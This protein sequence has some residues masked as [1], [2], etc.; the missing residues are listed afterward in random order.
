MSEPILQPKINNYTVGR[1]ALY[2][3]PFLDPGTQLPGGERFFGDV[4]GVDFTFK[5]TDLDHYTSLKGIKELDDSV[6][7]QVDRTGQFTTENIE[8]D[9]LA[10]FFLGAQSTITQTSG[11]VTAEVHNA[12]N[13]DRWYQMGATA[14]NPVGTR[15]LDPASAAVV[16][17]DAGSPVTYALGTD[18]LFDYQTGR[19]YTI[20]T[21]TIV[22]GVTN[23]KVTYHKL[24]STRS[25]VIS[26]S[27]PIEGQLHFVADNPNGPSRDA[28]VPWCRITP[29]GNYSLIGDKFQALVF[30]LK[31]LKKTQYSLEA[32]YI[33]DRGIS[34]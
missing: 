19:L 2:F 4:N 20:P 25:Q 31:I 17:N 10:L 27:T 12:V 30:D 18:Y 6:P 33:D 29:N 28:L 32:L 3:A 23:L 22:D 15:N 11:T 7:L 5:S 34:S 14:T 24:A 9:N 1:G 21:G 13:L 8:P 26:G 16:T